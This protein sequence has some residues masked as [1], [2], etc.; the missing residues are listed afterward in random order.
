MPTRVWSG[1]ERAGGINFTC[2]HLG[3]GS[4]AE[5]FYLLH[6]VL[7]GPDTPDRSYLTSLTDVAHHHLALGWAALVPVA[8]TGC[9][10]YGELICCPPMMHGCRG[11]KLSVHNVLSVPYLVLLTGLGQHES[12]QNTNP[13]ILTHA[14]KIY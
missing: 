7:L 8:I 9:L 12:P 6:D 10:G 11:L 5:F 4:I 3:N 1:H 13:A 14:Y 2:H